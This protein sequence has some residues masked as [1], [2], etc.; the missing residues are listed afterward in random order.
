LQLANNIGGEANAL[1]RPSLARDDD[2]PGSSATRGDDLE[3]DE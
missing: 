3:I 1:S 2:P